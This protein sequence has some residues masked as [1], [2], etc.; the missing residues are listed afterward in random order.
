M[1]LKPDLMRCIEENIN[2]VTYKDYDVVI[3]GLIL[4]AFTAIV[5]VFGL[6]ETRNKLDVCERK[7]LELGYS[8]NN[9]TKTIEPK[10]KLVFNK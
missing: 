7:L 8:Y 10:A 4:S 9:E 2:E 3:V 6:I 1:K 5:A